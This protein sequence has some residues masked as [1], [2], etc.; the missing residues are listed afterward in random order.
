MTWFRQTDEADGKRLEALKYRCYVLNT[1]KLPFDV[2][3]SLELLAKIK[4]LATLEILSNY[5]FNYDPCLFWSYEWFDDF[6]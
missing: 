2:A 5:N 4:K 6:N 3:H 1:E